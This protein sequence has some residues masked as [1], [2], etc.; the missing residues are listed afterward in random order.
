MKWMKTETKDWLLQEWEIIQRWEKEQK[1]LWFW[2]KIGRLPFVLLDKWTPS[3]IRQ[4]L[5]S[6]LDE[7]GSYIQTGGNYLIDPNDMLR[8]LEKAALLP[9][10]ELSIN[11]IPDLPL[12]VMDEVAKKLIASRKQWAT[13]QGATTGFGGIFTLLIDIPALLGLALKVLQEMALVYGYHPHDRRERVFIVQCLQF[14]ASDYVGKQA[15]LKKLS[16]FDDEIPE[17]ES[18]SQLQGWREVM[19]TFSDQF[20]WKKLF[21]II[22]VIGIPIGAWLNRSLLA[23]VAETGHMLY[24]KRRIAERLRYWGDSPHSST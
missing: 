13:V 20:T 23:D 21:Q 18:I 16:H 4:A 14:A 10:N 24:R 22:P 15:I 19:V 2:E 1:D 11:D 8:E 7:L 3:A 6:M 12:Q 9:P 5:G 17:R